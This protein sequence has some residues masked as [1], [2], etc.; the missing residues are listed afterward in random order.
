MTRFT[1]AILCALVFLASC[2]RS[3]HKDM[4]TPGQNLAKSR[5]RTDAG[6]DR[7]SVEDRRPATDTRRPDDERRELF[8]QIVDDDIPESAIIE[9]KPFKWFLRACAATT[10]D[11]LRKSSKEEVLFDALMAQPGLF[12]GQVITLTRGVIVEAKKV[13]LPDEYNMPGSSVVQA[14]F[15]DATHDVYALRI[16]CAPDSK[17]FDKLQKGIDEDQYPVMRMSG[18]FMKLYARQTNREGEPPWRRPLLICP[19]PEFSKMIEPR[20]LWR[21]FEE[22]K[23]N[24]LLP[25]ERITAPGAEER[26]LV[27]VT[28]PKQG[29]TQPGI[30]A[31]GE[32]VSGDLE[33]GIAKAVDAFKKRLPKAEQDEPAAVILMG[34]GS[35]RDPVEKLVSALR[36]AGVKRLAIKRE[37]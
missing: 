12:R 7:P 26:M 19:E 34:P 20:S 30:S 24:D 37:Q 9:G 13:K 15:V 11:N 29:A 10:H 35:P 31:N 1:A 3:E 14:I 36:A 8:A 32:A 2:K 21:D 33:E 28:T 23:V 4:P 6:E 5:P 18:Y 17:L 27:Q 22:G 16:L 25:S